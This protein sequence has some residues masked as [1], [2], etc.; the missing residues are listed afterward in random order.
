MVF[1]F[2]RD[3]EL[4]LAGVVD[5]HM[6]RGLTPFAFYESAVT[7]MNALVCL[8]P[9]LM[10]FSLG[11]VS[12]SLSH[13]SA[14]QLGFNLGVVESLFSSRAHT[15]LQINRLARM[16]HIDDFSSSEDEYDDGFF[17]DAGHHWDDGMSE[18][19]HCRNH[20]MPWDTDELMYSSPSDDDCY[21]V[22][23]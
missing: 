4:C 3:V 22:W 6:E 7:L 18:C 2:V 13:L 20:S 17:W 11:S 16:M 23:G 5:T 19:E 10:R 15:S 8:L 14:L 1:Y 12:L 21:N 9:L